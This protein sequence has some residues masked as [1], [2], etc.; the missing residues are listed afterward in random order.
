MKLEPYVIPNTKI[1]S[2]WINTNV[3]DKNLKHFR[4]RKNCI[5]ITMQEYFI[6]QKKVLTKK[7]ICRSGS[8]LELDTEQQTGSK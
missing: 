5:F 7:P 1:K 3:K 4:E 8:K 6:N 2:R